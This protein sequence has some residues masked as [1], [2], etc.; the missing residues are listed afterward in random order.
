M[1][2]RRSPS[3]PT[4]L[5]A[6]AASVAALLGGPPACAPREHPAVPPV[7]EV[8]V[9]AAPS[10]PVTPGGTATPPLDASDPKWIAKASGNPFFRWPEGSRPRSTGA[11]ECGVNEVHRDLV[12]DWPLVPHRPE[13]CF[14]N[15]GCPQTP[16]L[17]L[18]RCTEQERDATEIL[19]FLQDPA[20]WV[21]GSAVRL[22]GPVHLF[23]PHSSQ[24][25]NGHASQPWGGPP[26]ACEGG[27]SGALAVQELVDG[28]CFG[29]PIRPSREVELRCRGDLSRTCCAHLPMGETLVVSGKLEVS[30]FPD[31]SVLPILNLQSACKP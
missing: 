9:D 27:T 4:L 7:T 2:P 21:N 31:G 28:R 5:A 17:V 14:E 8:H 29:I 12:R 26:L 30:A 11:E 20:L 22:S 18:P 16:P 25:M 23:L 19:A 13:T 6:G 24:M 1:T 15:I 3:R 10:S